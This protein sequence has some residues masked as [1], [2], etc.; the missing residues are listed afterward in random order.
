VALASQAILG[1]LFG[2]LAILLDKPFEVGDAIVV[3][4]FMGT[5][6]NVGIKTT[7]LRSVGGEQLIFSNTDLTSSRVRNYKRMDL[8]RVV[9]KLG[10]V[11][12][13]PLEKTRAL[14][15]VLQDI[16]QKTPG[17]RFDRAHFFSF[18]ESCLTYEIVY[19]VLSAEYNRYMDIQQAIN[20]DIKSAF[21][22]MGVEF[23]FPTRTLHVTP[24]PPAADVK[25]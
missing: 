11:Y 19:Y 20:F 6:E 5:V 22:K 4:E 17:T 21:E 10:V 2:Y 8:R 7:R 3:N 14:P 1:D 12:D 13:T 9:F 18:D 23:A 24:A 15:G 25:K 16:I